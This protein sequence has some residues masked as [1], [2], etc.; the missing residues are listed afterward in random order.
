M[1]D[2]GELMISKATSII[3]QRK[4]KVKKKKDEQHD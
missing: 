1:R 4:E 2:R 3:V